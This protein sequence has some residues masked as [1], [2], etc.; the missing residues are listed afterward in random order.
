MNNR[1]F[2]DGDA[3]NLKKMAMIKMW[4][5]SPM[6]SSANDSSLSMAH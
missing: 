4:M 2:K 6:N 3:A 5:I 1:V